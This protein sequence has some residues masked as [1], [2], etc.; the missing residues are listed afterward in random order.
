MMRPDLAWRK[1]VKD[2]GYHAAYCELALRLSGSLANEETG[3]SSACAVV[4]AKFLGRVY[5]WLD[6]IVASKFLEL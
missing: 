1:A 4:P 3:S 5:Y 6:L 2:L